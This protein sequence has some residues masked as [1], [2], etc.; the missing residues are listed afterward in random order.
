MGAACSG[1]VTLNG[2]DL[3]CD[4][5]NGWRLVDDNTFE[6]TGSACTSFLG[7]ASSVYAMFPCE[8]FRP[9]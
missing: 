8:V 9:D 1:K 7:S 2:K 3:E 6:L 5:D 4:S